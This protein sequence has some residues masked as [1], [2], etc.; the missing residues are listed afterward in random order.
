[1]AHRVAKIHIL[2]TP[3]VAFKLMHNYPMKILVVHGIVRAKCGSI[4]VINDTVV[5]MG[6]IVCAEVCNERRDFA[7]KLDVK[8]FEH[9]KSV[10]ARQTPHNPIDIGIVVLANTKL[11][12]GIDAAI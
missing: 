1:M 5:G 2:H 4:I 7:L 6:R 10:A 11:K 12:V 8:R 9:I 3:A